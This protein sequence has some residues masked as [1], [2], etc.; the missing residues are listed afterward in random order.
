MSLQTGYTK[1]AVRV[2]ADAVGIARTPY[3]VCECGHK[4]NLPAIAHMPMAGYE[5]L[6]GITYDSRGWIIG[7]REAS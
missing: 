6:C 7:K 3:V 4:V 5:C 1:R 2:E